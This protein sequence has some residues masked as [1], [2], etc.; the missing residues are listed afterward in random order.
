MN[1]YTVFF[2]YVAGGRTHFGCRWHHLYGRLG[3]AVWPRGAREFARGAPV[4]LRQASL[5]HWNSCWLSGEKKRKSTLT[6][7]TFGY[8]HRNVDYGTAACLLISRGLFLDLGM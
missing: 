8:L 7:N 2:D 6:L 3:V 4:R 1:T 5:P